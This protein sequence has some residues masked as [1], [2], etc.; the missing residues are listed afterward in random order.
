MEVDIHRHSNLHPH[1]RPQ[2]GHDKEVLGTQKS[3]AA[4]GNRLTFDA[5]RLLYF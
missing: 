1:F 5:R 3:L 2:F 4:G